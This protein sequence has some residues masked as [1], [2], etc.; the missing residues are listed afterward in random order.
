SV[1]KEAEPL[2]LPNREAEVRARVEAVLA[3]PAL[4]R[5][6][7]DDVIARSDRG[8]AIA[9][10]LDDARSFVPEDRGR[11][12]GRVGT[13]GRVEVRVADAAGDQADEHLTGFRLGEIELLDLERLAEPLE[14]RGA[15]LHGAILRISGRGRTWRCLVHV[16]TLMEESDVGSTTPVE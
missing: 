1:R 11:I 8:D 6:E 2:L 10:C 7:R 12:A 16:V 13:R 14:H 15:D 5:E 4:R 9:N 3:L